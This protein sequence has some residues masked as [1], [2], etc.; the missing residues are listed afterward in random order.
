[1]DTAATTRTAASLRW[2]SEDTHGGDTL[3]GEL[4]TREEARPTSG[5]PRTSSE[6]AKRKEMKETSSGKKACSGGC[7][8]RGIDSERLDQNCK[9]ESLRKACRKV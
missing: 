6:A 3:R 2:R 7:P 5:C 8:R 4:R 1:M 9:K